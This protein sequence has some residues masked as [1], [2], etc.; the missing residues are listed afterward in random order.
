MDKHF[1]SFIADHVRPEYRR[2]AEALVALVER[3]APE[4]KPGMRGGTEKYIPVPVWRMTHDVVVM[5]PSQRGITLS[6]ANGALFDDAAGLLRGM[7]KKSRTVLL[8]RPEEVQR[9]EIVGLLRQAVALMGSEE[10]AR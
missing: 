5:S 9:P 4:L 3:A 1:E 7:G 6:F 10:E 2:V 8:R